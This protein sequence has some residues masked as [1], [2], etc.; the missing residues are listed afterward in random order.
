M[1]FFPLVFKG[2]KKFYDIKLYFSEVLLYQHEMSVN[3]KNNN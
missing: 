3:N 2:K 1:I